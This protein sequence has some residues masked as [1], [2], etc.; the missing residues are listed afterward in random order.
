VIVRLHDIKSTATFA[1]RAA[2]KIIDALQ[3]RRK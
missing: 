2:A 1:G 3:Q